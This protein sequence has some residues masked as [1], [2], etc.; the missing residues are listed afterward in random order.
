MVPIPGTTSPRR[1]EENVAALSVGLTDDE[2]AELDGI[3]PPR[4]SFPA[5][6]TPRP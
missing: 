4:G 2:R 3:A 6:A 1:I 5:T